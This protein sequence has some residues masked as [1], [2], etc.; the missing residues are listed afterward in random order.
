MT[1][2][3][4]ALADILSTI[5]FSTALLFVILL[6][7]D[8]NRAY[9]RPVKAFMIV[10][11]SLYVFVG[12]SNVLEWGGITKQLDVYEDYAELLFIP[13]MA[14]LVF[15]LSTAQRFEEMQRAD[16][17][18]RGEQDLLSSVVGASPTGIVVAD[19]D[20][21]V[22]F[23]NT[24]AR[25]VLGLRLPPPGHAYIA[26]DDVR[27]G[28]DPGSVS[29]VTEGLRALVAQGVVDDVVRYA[30]H[31]GGRIVALDVGV[32]PLAAG[33]SVHGGSVVVFADMTERLRYRQD[34]ERAVDARTREL[35][36]LNRELAVANDAKRDFLA[37]MSHELRGPLNSIIGFTGTMLQG[38]AGE[39]SGE[40]RRQLEMIRSS[41]SHLLDLV[42]D[43]VDIELIETGRTKVAHEPVDACEIVRS[44]AELMRPLVADKEID[45]DTDC[46]EGAVTVL[47]DTDK[48]SQVVRSLIANAV[49]HSDLGGWVRTVVR[50]DASA[51]SIAVGDSGPGIAPEDLPHVF[52]AFTRSADGSAG[53]WGGAGLGLAICRDLVVLLGGEIS[54]DSQ[55][56]MGTTFTVTLPLAEP[57]PDEAG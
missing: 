33:R 28:T 46:P 19:D 23:A 2:S 14:Y 40:Q 35:I 47:S 17:L 16:E 55:A 57:G 36:E 39:L 6:P 53:S 51:V 9:L 37:R 13:L 31:P 26:P 22:T 48:L 54:V 1:T 49:R 56:G 25:D 30:E 12:V 8:P 29:S 52:D 21:T 38:A 27:L 11:M 4:I 44:V 7:I 10:A 45:L 3:P 20:G 5:T 42:N 32:R 15:S 34:L 43:V 18:V 41:G 24:L 50:R